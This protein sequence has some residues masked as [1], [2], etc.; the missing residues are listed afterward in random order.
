MEV[1]ASFWE[2][3]QS[4]QDPQLGESILG[5]MSLGLTMGSPCQILRPRAGSPRPGSPQWPGCTRARRQG[6]IGPAGSPSVLHFLS[7]LLWLWPELLCWLH[8]TNSGLHEEGAQGATK[9]T[10]SEVMYFQE[11]E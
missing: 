1:R 4:S 7:L 3:H 5:P 10:L 8:R 11:G 6:R 2:S 9:H